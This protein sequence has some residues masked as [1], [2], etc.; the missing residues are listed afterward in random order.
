MFAKR[1]RVGPSKTSLRNMTQQRAAFRIVKV[2]EKLGK[3]TIG[4]ITHTS[5]DAKPM[6]GPLGA[7][8]EVFESETKNRSDREGAGD[9]KRAFGVRD[10][11]SL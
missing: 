3:S 9:L 5:T 7:S 2:G 8:G 10:E 11:R 4:N 6:R 1:K